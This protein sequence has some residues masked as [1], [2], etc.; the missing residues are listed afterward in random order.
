MSEYR[1]FH[2]GLSSTFLSVRKNFFHKKHFI[3][4]RNCQDFISQLSFSGDLPLVTPGR[5]LDYSSS[6]PG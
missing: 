6:S 3:F 5:G 4:I 2:C 1:S